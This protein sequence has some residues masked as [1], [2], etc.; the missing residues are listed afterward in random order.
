MPT[1]KPII[2]GSTLEAD[3]QQAAIVLTKEKSKKTNEK[4]KTQKKTN[5]KSTQ[6][7]TNSPTNTKMMTVCHIPKRDPSA[8]YDKSIRSSALK[9]HLDHGDLEGK[10][11]NIC[12]SFCAR[13]GMCSADNMSKCTCCK[14]EQDCFKGARDECAVGRVS[15]CVFNKDLISYGTECMAEGSVNS[16]LR[17]HL[18][19]YYGKCEEDIFVKKSVLLNVPPEQGKEIVGDYEVDYNVSYNEDGI[20]VLS[21]S[22]EIIDWVLCSNHQVDIFFSKPLAPGSLSSMFPKSAILVVNGDLFGTRCDFVPEYEGVQSE[23]YN[24]GFFIIELSLVD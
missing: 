16:H 2:E 10:C 13:V 4:S 15:V 22:F 24:V 6:M 9:A 18:S 14:C 1:Q 12:D 5:K 17:E 8:C 11:E 19:D 20:V 23:R 21:K 3:S 7:P